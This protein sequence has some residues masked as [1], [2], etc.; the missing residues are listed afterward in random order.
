MG[1]RIECR[2][3]QELSVLYAL[4][5]L[6]DA[7]RAAAEAH[8]DECPDCAARLHR[9][10]EL[11]K[12]VAARVEA[13]ERLDR[14]GLLLARC[15]SELAE[16]LDDAETR[17]AKPGWLGLLSPARW[18]AGFR[19]ALALHPGWSAAALLVAGAFGG[20]ALRVW[21]SET[22][23]PLPNRPVMTVSAAPRLSDRE[24]DAMAVEGIRRESQSDGAPPLVEIQMVSKRP[25]TLSGSPD[26]SNIRRV[27][28]YVLA[29]GQRF[30]PGVRLDSVEM[31]QSRA[32]EPQV[33]RALCEAARHDRNPAVRLKALEALHGLGA[34]PGV[35]QAMLA[36]LSEDENSGVRVEAVN[37]LLA[38]FEGGEKHGT[39]LDAEARS[40]L[41]DRMQNDPNS[42]VRLRSAVALGLLA[43]DQTGS[44]AVPTFAA[45]PHP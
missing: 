26:D 43:S 6:D 39:P 2:D 15:R 37:A 13:A 12:A 24:L 5:E 19:R 21:Y 32:D 30:D 38:A 17:A 28:T 1:K 4:D 40:I 9:E 45:S 14:S 16:A 23:L 31:L 20:T 33:R 34:D 8:A 35:Q 41:R 22:S 27:L 10:I 42:Y 7:E 44:A 25:V 18:G 3:M 11:R 29:H 36:A